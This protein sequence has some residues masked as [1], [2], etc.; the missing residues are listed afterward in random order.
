MITKGNYSGTG[1]TSEFETEY[2]GK[3][4]LNRHEH[5]LFDEDK[6]LVEKVVQ[7]RKTLLP[8]KNEK[9]RIICDNK[10]V[11]VVESL[12]ISKKEKEFLRT[13]DGFNFLIKQAKAGIKSLNQL[14]IELKKV[15]KK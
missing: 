5:D 14:R 10:T 11:F 9:W 3:N 7:V 13:A 8:N 2:G 15:L 6:D 12:K 4:I 1:A